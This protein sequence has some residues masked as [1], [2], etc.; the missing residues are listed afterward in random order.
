M[1]RVEH[2]GRPVDLH[3]GTHPTRRSC[4]FD[5]V[6]YSRMAMMDEHQAFAAMT[7]FLEDFYRRVGNELE[8]LIVDI[9]LQ[10]DGRPLDRAAWEDWMR[11]VDRVVGESDS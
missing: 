9:G 11:F 6:Q 4:R 1:P 8:I 7:L 5:P 3:P 2:L 10:P